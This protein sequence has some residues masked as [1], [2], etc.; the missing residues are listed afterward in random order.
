MTTDPLNVHSNDLVSVIINRN[1][2]HTCM[3]IYNAK[4]IHITYKHR[5]RKIKLTII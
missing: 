4:H 2:G 5:R 3:V 1:T